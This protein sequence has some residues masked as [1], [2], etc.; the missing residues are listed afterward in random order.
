MIY[1]I[2]TSDEVETNLY[3]GLGIDDVNFKPL[4]GLNKKLI[5][6]LMVN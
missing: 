3:N 2:T 1:S 5:K 6:K 4:T